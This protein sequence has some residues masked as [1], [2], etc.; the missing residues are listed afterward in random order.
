MP[1]PD[2]LIRLPR[3][4]GSAASGL[5]RRDRT[6]L[7]LERLLAENLLP[8]MDETE[9]RSAPEEAETIPDIAALVESSPA[10]RAL[11]APPTPLSPKK[12]RRPARRAG[13]KPGS[14]RPSPLLQALQVFIILL[15]VVW[16][17]LLGVLVGRSQLREDGWG[18]DLMTW[19]GKKADG[20]EPPRL[21]VR[22]PAIEATAP[23][24]SEAV[25]VET[26]EETPEFAEKPLPPA[27]PGAE[28]E[29]PGTALTVI[30][31]AEEA[32]AETNRTPTN[33]QAPATGA[34]RGGEGRFA[35][36]IAL[37][38]DETEARRRVDKLQAQ[39]FSAY[40]Y[41][42]E[43]GHRFSVRVGR[44]Q[45]RAEAENARR[46]LEEIGYKSPYLSEL[47]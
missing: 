30:G 7:R 25:P 45:T 28:E 27:S 18:Q 22:S 4:S 46:R 35:V 8:T 21:I 1:T 38:Y 5:S 3:Q 20:N 47:R 6:L 42:R 14:A 17:F 12:G 37:A 24:G 19:L 11:T 29:E 23:A 40:F 43:D 15:V 32:P 44:F 2:F 33:P 31:P 13:G 9:D 10:L 39:G 34:D 36:Q 26:A 16:V 41:R